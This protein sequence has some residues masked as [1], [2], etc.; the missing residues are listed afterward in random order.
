MTNVFHISRSRDPSIDGG[1]AT[2]AKSIVSSQSLNPSLSVHWITTDSLTLTS[3]FRFLCNMLFDKN[4]VVH[5]HGL[6]FAG[7][8]LHPL[9]PSKVIISPHGMLNP[10][11]L[12]LSYWKKS[13]FL[14]WPLRQIYF[15]N[16]LFVCPTLTEKLLIEKA[17]CTEILAQVI[18]YPILMPKLSP[19]YIPPW[20]PF[21]PGNARTILYFG[22][23]HPIK[24]LSC[25]TQ[26]WVSLVDRRSIPPNAYLI[27]VGFGDSSLITSSVPL[28][29]SL[30]HYRILILPPIYGE[31]KFNCLSASECVIL[32]SISECM[33]MSVLESFS[34][35]TPAL[36]S[37]QCNL[38]D[39]MSHGASITF[40]PKLSDICRAL[41]SYFDAPHS[42]LVQRKAKA[43]SY[44]NMYHDP[45]LFSRLSHSCYSHYYHTN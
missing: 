6:W 29:S 5:I 37:D 9:F 24:N 15:K 8:F 32:P 39:S 34:S 20:T 7:F 16:V 44:I 14:T 4:T 2:V 17:L 42:D 41:I 33:P 28:Q 13:L 30:N 12:K 27:F 43:I 21:L 35:G 40:T 23:F 26:A 3:L 45:L 19:K 36:L 11:C 31:D 22:R 38:N 1:V 18:R 25:L 10:D